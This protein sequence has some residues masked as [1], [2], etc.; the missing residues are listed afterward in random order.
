[1]GTLSATV[2]AADKDFACRV[3]TIGGLSGVVLV[4]AETKELAAKAAQGATAF[5]FDN[6]TGTATSGVKCIDRWEE[7][8]SDYQ[9]QQFFE[10]IGL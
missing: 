7:Q 8:F 3:V 9:F 10:S 2:L 4:Q 6:Q 1:L 5:T